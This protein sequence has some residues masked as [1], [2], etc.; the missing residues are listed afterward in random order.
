MAG[1]EVLAA[2]RGAAVTRRN[3]AIEALSD[4]TGTEPPEQRGSGKPKAGSGEWYASE[5]GVSAWMA[6]Q[7]ARQQIGIDELRAALNG[8]KGKCHADRVGRCGSQQGS[9]RGG[10][11]QS[12]REASC[13]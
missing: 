12:R 8:R 10:T 3:R 6:E 1:S 4:R 7:L 11:A 2:E 5:A 9:P 13:R